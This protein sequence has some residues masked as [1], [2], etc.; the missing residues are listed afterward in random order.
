MAYNKVKLT[1]ESTKTIIDD[2]QVYEENHATGDNSSLIPVSF[3]SNAGSYIVRIFPDVHKGRTRIARHTFLHF[4][5]FKNPSNNQ[6][7]KLRVVNDIRLSK[8]LEEFSDSDLGNEK[9]KFDS[10]EFSLMLVRMYHAPA[11]DTYLS[12][13]LKESKDG[14]ID[15]ILVLKPRIMKEIQARIGE[16]TP[17]QLNEFLDIDTKSFALK[18]ELKPETSSDGKFSWLSAEVSVTREQYDMGMP[19]F[20][21]GCEYD[22]LESAYIPEDKVITDLELS[23]LT[24]Y[25]RRLK[26]RNANYI[27]SKSN[28]GF[29]NHKSMEDTSEPTWNSSGYTL[30]GLDDE[31][32]F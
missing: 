23:M 20:P 29:D 31:A 7:V 19:K 8:M 5:N 14:F 18:I 32:P 26:E 30:G 28:D 24:L 3:M 27:N 21:E 22:G 25:L 12:K 2:A 10:K 4:L 15:L 11:S 13:A 6:D 16:L 9:F 17:S 1:E